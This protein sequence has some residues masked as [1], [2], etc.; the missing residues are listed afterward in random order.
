MWNPNAWLVSP[1]FKSTTGSTTIRK[2]HKGHKDRKISRKDGKI[3][4]KYGIAAKER[5]ERKKALR[6]LPKP[7]KTSQQ[8]H[9]GHKEE[10][11]DHSPCCLTAIGVKSAFAEPTARRVLRSSAARLYSSCPFAYIR[12]PSLRLCVFA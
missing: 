8:E 5:I 3:E 4:D 1:R 6:P 11:I 2:D 9:K 7:F 12:G 10:S